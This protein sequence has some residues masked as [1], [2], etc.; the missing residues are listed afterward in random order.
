MKKKILVIEDDEDIRSA[1]T[2]QLVKQGF[3]V[4]TAEDGEEGLKEIRE[5][6]P[7]LV[8]LD[9][10]LPK[11]AGEEVCKT[12]KDGYDK[13]LRDIPI[14]M[15][16]AKTG[17]VDRVVGGVIGASRYITKPFEDEELMKEIQRCLYPGNV[18]NF[19]STGSKAP[20]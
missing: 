9:L 18:K 10:G 20:E 17:E 5:E 4:S 6:I 15:L 13:T 19:P 8:I 1:L 14:I 7:D 16:T 12:V 11:L 3:I 2:F